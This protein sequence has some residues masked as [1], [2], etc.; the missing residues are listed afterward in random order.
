MIQHIKD[1]SYCYKDTNLAQT[2]SVLNLLYDTSL[3]C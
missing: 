2:H 1:W 3:Y